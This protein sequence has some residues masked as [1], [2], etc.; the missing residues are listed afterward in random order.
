MKELIEYLESI[1][2]M[3]DTAKEAVREQVDFE[4]EK[5]RDILERTAPRGETGGLARSLTK[6]QITTR[7]DWY[8]FRIE[9]EGNNE[10]GVPYS[11][12][13]NILNFGSSYIQGTRFISKAIRK[14]RGMDERILERFEDKT[15]NIIDST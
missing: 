9:F 2:A 12:I 5:V 10:R 11:K 3:D 1:S 15:N 4:A 6:V 14:L 7:K 8:G 13:A